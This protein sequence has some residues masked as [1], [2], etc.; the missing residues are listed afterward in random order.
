MR[1]S[2]PDEND[3]KY[4]GRFISNVD[5][6]GVSDGENIDSEGMGLPLNV[7]NY[8]KFF[9][10]CIKDNYVRVA[11]LGRSRGAASLI[12]YV[13]QENSPSFDLFLG[14]YPV[15]DWE[16]YPTL[17]VLKE[18]K[19]YDESFLRFY[20]PGTI[21]NITKFRDKIDNI[22][23]LHGSNDKVVPFEKHSLKLARFS[24]VEIQLLTGLGHDF[25]EGYFLNETLIQKLDNYFYN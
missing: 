21:I 1:S 3:L 20:N 16:S 11:L 17:K 10:L 18:I 23:I 8:G 25:S 15:V 2:Y 13:R 9:N 14:I 7:S 6:G 12:S 19:N 4:L 5:I 22:F 24:N